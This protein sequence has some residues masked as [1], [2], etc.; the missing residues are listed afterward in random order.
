MTMDLSNAPPSCFPECLSS[1]WKALSK[2]WKDHPILQIEKWSLAR[3]PDLPLIELWAGSWARQSSINQ[4]LRP[5][6]YHR[7]FWSPLEGRVV[8]VACVNAVPQASNL[9]SGQKVYFERGECSLLF[10][11][12]QCNI[13]TVWRYFGRGRGQRWEDIHGSVLRAGDF[14]PNTDGVQSKEHS[15]FKLFLFNS[16]GAVWD[17]ILFLSSLLKKV[18]PACKVTQH[19]ASIAWPLSTCSCVILY[20]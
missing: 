2:W 16:K 15:S 4:R 20:W 14:V 3:F 7:S 1:A 6:W 8:S 19:L 17:C 11:N 10:R 12:M 9:R 5:V 18:L 13:Q